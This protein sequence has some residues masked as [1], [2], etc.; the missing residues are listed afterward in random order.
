VTG[1][2]RDLH[3]GMFGGA[4]TNPLTVLARLV[5][6]LHDAEGRVAIPGF[7]DGVE[8]LE[9]WEREAWA[10][11]PLTEAALLAATG[12]PALGGEPGYT[13]LER[14]WG[15]PT[16]EVNG[17]YGGYQGEG[18]KTVLPKEARAK[19]TFRLVPGQTGPAILRLAEQHL[20][21]QAPPSVRIEVAPGHSGDPYRT[22]PRSGHGLLAQEALREAFP[23]APLALTRE[24]GSIPIVT[25][26]QR[27]LGVDTLLL[28][29]CLPDCNAHSPN[30]TFPVAHLEAGMRLNQALLRRLA[31]GA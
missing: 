30:E 22:S 28:G 3:S 8:P 17:L 4:V 24:G 11:L 31:K 15:R 12:A 18:S 6:S 7:Y 9:A 25:D 16:A 20:R 5:A 29:L 26:F 2:A 10:A 13:P 14:I 23:G 1:P 19:L 21:R 27:I